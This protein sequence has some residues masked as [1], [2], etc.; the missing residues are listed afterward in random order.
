M[1]SYVSPGTTELL[2]VPVANLGTFIGAVCFLA[3]G[4]RLLFER[5]E[6]LPAVTAAPPR[7]SG[8]AEP[9]RPLQVARPVLAGQVLPETVMPALVVQGEAGALVDA[10]GVG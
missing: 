6:E 3:G 1:A 10:P 9:A 8:P 5:T 4:V 2:S 7:L